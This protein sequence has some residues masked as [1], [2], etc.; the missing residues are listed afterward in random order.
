MRQR[1]RGCGQESC[2]LQSPTAVAGGRVCP[3]RS[4][5][6]AIDNETARPHGI[7]FAVQAIAWRRPAALPSGQRRGAGLRGPGVC[8]C[9][10]DTA[11]PMRELPQGAGLRQAE[12]RI[13]GRGQAR[14]MRQRSR[15]GLPAGRFPGPVPR[16]RA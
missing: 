15:F 5:I 16:C 8:W 12:G 6:Q 3:G 9:S 4:V 10:L 2:A 7:A 14:R 11:A 1:Q 13:V